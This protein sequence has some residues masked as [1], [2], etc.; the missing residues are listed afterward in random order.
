MPLWRYGSAMTYVFIVI[1][2]AQLIGVV[3][4]CRKEETYEPTC[5]R[6]PLWWNGF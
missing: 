5:A 1:C 2:A 6:S 3:M 4:M